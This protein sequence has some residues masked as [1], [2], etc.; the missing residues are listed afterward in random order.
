VDAFHATTSSGARSPREVGFDDGVLGVDL[1]TE[2]SGT[3]GCWLTFDDEGAHAELVADRLD[4]G[5]LIRLISRGT[6]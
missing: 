4:D 5:T 3:A 6:A 2:P 1:A